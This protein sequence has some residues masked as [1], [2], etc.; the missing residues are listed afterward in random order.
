MSNCYRHDKKCLTQLHN[1]L[2]SVAINAYGR[3]K[4]LDCNLGDDFVFT[5][6]NIFVVY[7]FVMIDMLYYV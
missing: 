7:M 6:K 5:F 3:A 1:H 2:S 4:S